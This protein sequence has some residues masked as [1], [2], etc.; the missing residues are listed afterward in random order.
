MH[1]FVRVRIIYES[2]SAAM[3]SLHFAFGL[4]SIHHKYKYKS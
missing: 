2:I 3:R 4:G 1:I